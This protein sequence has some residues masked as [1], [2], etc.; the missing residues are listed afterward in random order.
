LARCEVKD[1]LGK[2]LRSVAAG[3][4]KTLGVGD[5]TLI[6]ILAELE[7]PGRDPRPAFEAATFD[8]HIMSLAD[9]KEGQVL[10]GIVTNVTDFGAFVDLGV[11]QDGLV[12][13]SQLADSYVRHPLD[14]VKPGQTI[15]VKVLG[16]DLDQKRISLS[17]KGLT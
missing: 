1:L 17:R 16:V 6:D 15:T 8:E 12:H 3:Q 14:V 7:R 10:R 4:A 13:I 9:L 11:H 2:D 5:A